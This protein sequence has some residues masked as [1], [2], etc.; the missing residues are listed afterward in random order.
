M[1]GWTRGPRGG[2]RARAAGGGP[3]LPCHLQQQSTPMQGVRRQAPGSAGLPWHAR[4]PSHHARPG[5][6]TAA[7]CS[8]AGRGGTA[9]PRPAPDVPG[10]ALSLALGWCGPA[11][12]PSCPNQRPAAPP[13][14]YTGSWLCIRPDSSE[15]VIERRGCSQ[16]GSRVWTFVMDFGVFGVSLARV[17]EGGSRRTSEGWVRVKIS[18]PAAQT[19]LPHHTPYTTKRVDQLA[20]PSNNP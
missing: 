10:L 3:R 18:A 2:R 5:V 8:R 4:Q 7:R 6:V 15:G 20:S 11:I 16:G 13:R 19:S 17:G 9:A 14:C 12:P 1:T